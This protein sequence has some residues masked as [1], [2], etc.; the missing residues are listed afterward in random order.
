MG[1]NSKKK[2]EKPILSKEEKNAKKALK[3][4]NQK[5]RVKSKTER[6]E[7]NRRK[8]VEEED[9]QASPR[10]T[11]STSK[12]KKMKKKQD[13]IDEL[14]SRPIIAWWDF[15][16]LSYPWVGV[17]KMILNKLRREGY[18]GKLELHAIVGYKGDKE[19]KQDKTFT[20]HYGD[21]NPRPT[22]GT[23]GDQKA[24]NHMRKL[25]NDFLEDEEMAPQNTLLITNDNGF[26][27]ELDLLRA[28]GHGVLLATMQKSLIIKAGSHKVWFWKHEI[29][30]QD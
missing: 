2:K 22:K 12:K 16:N 5:E 6:K 8:R 15:E 19:P 7:A 10:S 4:K 26:R 24:D 30:Q 27:E 18:T 13:R 29:V 25:I 23:K 11:A 28:S 17:Y 3:K 1:K 14:K 20:M 9:A 21:L